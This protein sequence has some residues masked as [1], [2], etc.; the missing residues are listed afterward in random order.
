MKKTLLL[1][2]TIISAHTMWAQDLFEKNTFAASNGTTLNY[3]EMTPENVD[4]NKKYPLVLFMHG[5]GE[6]GSDNTK[7]LTHG[8]RMFENPTNR[9]KYPAYVLFPQCPE[10]IFWT[11]EARPQ[12]LKA[13]SIPA[14][15]TPAALISA[16]K[17][18]L[19]KYRNHP[20]VDKDRVYIIGLSMGAMATF[21]LTGRYPDVFAAAIP[22]C[23]IVNPDH[24]A[25]TQSINFRIFHGD[26]DPVVPVSGSR[27]AYKKL[28]EIG[29]NVEYIEFPGISHDSWTAAFNH[30]DFMEWLF[31]QTKATSTQID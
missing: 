21:E 24:L 26:A 15:T 25:N 27:N 7:Q 1:I 22:I 9:E 30:P 12:E 19:D 4:P 23:G 11:F 31:K 2:L 20:N 6:R 14:S 28:K 10:P 17:E 13:D 8:S 18:L 3:R 29:A 16:V 5:A